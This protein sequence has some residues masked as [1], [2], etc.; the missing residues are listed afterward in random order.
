MPY[1]VSV[2]VTLSAYPYLGMCLIMLLLCAVAVLTAR[3]NARLLLLSGVLC[4]PY[5]LFSFEYIP[6]YWDPRVTFHY[7]SSPEDLLFSFC[8]GILATRMLL[9]FQPGTYS[10]T[11]EKGLV[12]KRYLLYSV[13]GIAIGYGVRF[14]VTGTPVM[15]STLSGVAVTGLI[16][17][18][19]RSRFVA[20][21][22]LG[23]LGFSLLYAVLVRSSFAIWPHFENAW[24]NAEVHT[25]WLLGVP[26]FEIYWAL[27]YGLVWPLLAVHCLLDE[28]AARRIAGVLPHE[29]PRGSQSLH[30]G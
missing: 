20:G 22:V 10:V 21:S 18:F 25:G 11:R 5:G 6:Q 1:N 12:W 17:A 3:R 29:L 9:F 13:I 7:I 30:G 26:L 2:L 15:V 14:G 28:E 19:K 27:G 16:L 24:R 4:I 23:A 8:A